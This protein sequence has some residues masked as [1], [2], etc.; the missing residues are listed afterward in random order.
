MR[1]LNI[2]VPRTATTYISRTLQP[3]TG[4][5][6]YVFEGDKCKNLLTNSY[7]DLQ[8]VFIFAFV[9]NPFEIL[10]SHYKILSEPYLIGHPDWELRNVDFYTYLKTVTNRTDAVFPM[11][12]KSLFFQLYNLTTNQF[13]PSYLGRFENLQK[14]LFE[15]ARITNSSYKVTN[16]INDSKYNS[17]KDFYDA[18]TISLV[19]SIY[20]EDLEK[21][22]YNFDGP[23]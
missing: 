2:G 13:V 15:I 10:V 19:E 6:H 7:I 1:T 18:K 8:N 22:G 16:K 20:G 21:F 14:D 17:Y 5:G 4:H 12:G 11:P 3:N 9:R 23:I